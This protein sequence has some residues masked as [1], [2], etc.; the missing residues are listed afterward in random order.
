LSAKSLFTTLRAF[1]LHDRQHRVGDPEKP[2][3]GRIMNIGSSQERFSIDWRT[4][5]LPDVMQKKC[6]VFADQLSEGSKRT[7]LRSASSRA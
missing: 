5:H 1:D 6:A 7:M 2:A 4:V 3:A